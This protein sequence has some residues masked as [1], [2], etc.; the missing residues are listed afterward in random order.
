M[1]DFS[2]GEARLAPISWLDHEKGIIHWRF[3]EGQPVDE[4]LEMFDQFRVMVEA[5]EH[6][7]VHSIL[8]FSGMTASPA[9][10]MSHFPAMGHRLPQFGSR[11]GIVTVVSQK[12]FISVLAGIFGRVYNFD[13]VYFDSFDDAYHHILS[14]LTP[15]DPEP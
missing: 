14:H 12:M 9:N 4:I 13:F 11:P 5:E 3:Y 10:I 2:G 1:I 7:K 15:P 6:P 8:D